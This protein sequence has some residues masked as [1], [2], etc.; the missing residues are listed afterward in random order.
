MSSML[1]WKLVPSIGEN[2]HEEDYLDLYG[3][4]FVRISDRM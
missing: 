4:F 2:E 3:V 1:K